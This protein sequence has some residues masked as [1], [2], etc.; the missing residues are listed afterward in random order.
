MFHQFPAI[1]RRLGPFDAALLETGAYNRLWPDLP[2]ESAA[3]HPVVSSELDPQGRSP[4][5]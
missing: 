5:R 3:E 2:W 4:A 1:A